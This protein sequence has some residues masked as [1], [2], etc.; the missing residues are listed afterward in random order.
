MEYRTIQD[1]RTL[2]GTRLILTAGVPGPWGES[3]KAVLRLR[4]VAYT[5]IAQELGGSNDEQFAW[6]G[7]R[8][9][10]VALHNDEKPR[11]GWAEILLLAERLGSGPS[12]LPAD[13][14]ERALMFGIAHEIAGENGLGWCRRLLIVSGP[15]EQGPAS[16]AYSF[17]KFFGDNYGY[18]AAAVASAETRCCEI[19]SMLSA[20]IARQQAAGKRY[21]VGDKLS[22][23]DLYWAAFANLIDPLPHELCP[24]SDDFRAMYGSSPTAVRGSASPALLAHRDFICESAF[25]LPFTF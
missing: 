25:G 5:P 3:A 21:F 11:G 4:N 7:I 9:A 10:P 13:P 16:P 2:T 17:A 20:Q 8:N 23:V 24:M 18:S 22:A 12:L 6:L 14:L 19:L 1:A 15:I